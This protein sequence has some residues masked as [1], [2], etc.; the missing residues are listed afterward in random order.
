VQV[1]VG[2]GIAG[3]L[4]SARSPAKRPPIRSALYNRGRTRADPKIPSLLA[5]W[6]GVF[7][8]GWFLGVAVIGAIVILMAGVGGDLPS[9]AEQP[10]VYQAF[11]A[12]AVGGYSGSA[13]FGVFVPVNGNGGPG[14]WVRSARKITL[15]AS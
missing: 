8:G 11:C 7:L 9:H 14:T 12:A 13:G 1:T 4:D 3:E 6:R 15:S 10:Q 5:G 2:E